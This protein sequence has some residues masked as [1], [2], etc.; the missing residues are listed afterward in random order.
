[1]RQL[2]KIQ[3]SVILSEILLEYRHAHFLSYCLW[4]LSCYSD[5][6]MQQ[7]RPYEPQNWKHLLFVTL[8]KSLLTLDVDHL[9]E[10][11]FQITIL[12]L[13]IF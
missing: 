8:G 6:V 2:Y 13:L 4:L 1:M 7:E 9:S 11:S 12:F 5:R 10:V 3:I